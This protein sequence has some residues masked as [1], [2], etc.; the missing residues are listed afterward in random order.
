MY[1]C[2]K[3][4]KQKVMKHLLKTIILL[5][6]FASI[7]QMVSAGNEQ[8]SEVR[9]STQQCQ[10]SSSEA[11]PSRAPAR[12]DLPFIVYYN[13]NNNTLEF[14]SKNYAYNNQ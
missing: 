10:W 13:Q 2:N 4:I 3:I 6:F 1:L 5:S 12:S 14:I 7:A 11:K 8:K 9:L